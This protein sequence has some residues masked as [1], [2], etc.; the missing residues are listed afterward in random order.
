MW[1]ICRWYLLPFLQQKGCKSVL[2]TAKN[3]QMGALCSQWQ[4]NSLNTQ[5]HTCMHSLL[6]LVVHQGQVA[7]RLRYLVSL[8]TTVPRLQ[9]LGCWRSYLFWMGPSPW[10]S[11]LANKVSAGFS[12][13]VEAWHSGRNDLW[14]EI[15]RR[16]H[17]L[18]H[19]CCACYQL[20]SDDSVTELWTAL[21]DQSILKWGKAGKSWPVFRLPAW[22]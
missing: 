8:A 1:H 2:V 12:F 21:T 5:P 7:F 18:M 13:T 16:Q 11:M 3:K 4:R 9:S 15:T 19:F 10:P 17:F 14:D 6:W 22:C 20:L